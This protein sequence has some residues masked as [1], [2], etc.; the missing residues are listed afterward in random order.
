VCGEAAAADAM[1]RVVDGGRGSIDGRFPGVDVA[2]AA[3][4]TDCEGD[5]F[6]ARRSA[7]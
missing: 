1:G 4:G 5:G 2:A 7:S 6:V 3:V